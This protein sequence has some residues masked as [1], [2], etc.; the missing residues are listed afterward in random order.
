MAPIEPVFSKA[1]SRRSW[2]SRGRRSLHWLSPRNWIE[3]GDG[4]TMIRLLSI[5]SSAVGSGMRSWRRDLP[6]RTSLNGGGE[7]S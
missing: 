2:T 6:S 4:L 3:V 7:I 5:V 1:C